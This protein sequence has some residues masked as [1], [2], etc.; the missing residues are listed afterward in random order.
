MAQEKNGE[1]MLDR[2]CGKISITWGQGGEEHSMYKGGG[3]GEE[4]ED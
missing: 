1:D 3:G 4:E 2:S